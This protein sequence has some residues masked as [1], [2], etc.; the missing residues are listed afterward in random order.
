MAYKIMNKKYKVFLAVI[1]LAL[2]DIAL[3][4]LS[5]I[6]ILGG[7]TETTTEIV[8]EAVTLLLI[9]PYLKR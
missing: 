8:I 1:V 7:L 6:P 2:V 3:N 4:S 9:F 5:V